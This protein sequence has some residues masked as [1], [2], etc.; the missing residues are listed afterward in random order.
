MWTTRDEEGNLS[1]LIEKYSKVMT[2]GL[3]KL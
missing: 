3:K 1:W 2:V